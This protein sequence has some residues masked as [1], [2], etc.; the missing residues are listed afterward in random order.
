MKII[1]GWDFKNEGRETL[2]RTGRVA[3]RRGKRGFLSE[4][5]EG[6]PKKGWDAQKR[7]GVHY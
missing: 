2:E 4:G 1:F 7:G 5:R 3:L 6:C